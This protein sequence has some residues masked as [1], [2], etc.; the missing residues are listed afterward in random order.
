MSESK[1]PEWVDSTSYAQGDRERG[2]EPNS[3]SIDLGAELLLTVHRLHGDPTGWYLS[4]HALIT[5]RYELFDEAGVPIDLER[6][7][8]L[9]RQYVSNRLF[10]LTQ[11][12]DQLRPSKTE[13]CE[14]CGC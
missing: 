5:S 6:A 14:G 8:E 7:K 1:K 3:W 4:C 11:A 13:F 12:I 2:R 10:Y 9:A